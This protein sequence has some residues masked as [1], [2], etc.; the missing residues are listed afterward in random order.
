MNEIILILS[1]ILSEIKK[2]SYRIKFIPTQY[3]QNYDTIRA[4]RRVIETITIRNE[5]LFTLSE[6][7]RSKSMCSRCSLFP[8][9]ITIYRDQTFQA[10]QIRIS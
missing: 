9:F 7:R 5:T 1:F 4:K 8:P 2:N 3:T 6:A 10:S